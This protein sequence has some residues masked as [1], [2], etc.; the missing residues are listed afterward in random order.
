VGGLTACEE[1][2]V[3]V[4]T[5]ETRLESAPPPAPR[6]P[7]AHWERFAA[8]CDSM[9]RAQLDS[10][11]CPGAA[12]VIVQDSNIIFQQGYGLRSTSGGLPVDEHTLFRLGSISK[13]F[14]GV[15]AGIMVE[16][17]VI[18]LHERVVDILPEFVL[19]DSA[20]T[21]RIRLWHLLSHSSGLPRHTY[22]SKVEGNEDRFAILASLTTVPLAGCEGGLFAYQ[23]FAFSLIEEI[24]A[25]RTCHSYADLVEANLLA[26]AG[27]KDATIRANEWLAAE[28]KALPHSND[29]NGNFHPVPINDKYF[30][31]PSAGGIA[32]S[33]TDMGAWLK[34]L[35]GHR[36][37][38]ASVAAL[39]TA[40]FPRLE[41]HSRAF[42]DRWECALGSYYGLG[43]R[44]IDLGDHFI[45]CHGG[46]VNHYRSEIAFDRKAG[47]GVCFLYNATTSNQSSAPPDFFALYN[48][49]MDALAIE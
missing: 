27:M 20:Q 31:A 35:L 11:H 10:S 4:A 48:A 42:D 26:A 8:A 45:I 16:Q 15:L 37:E 5:V 3:P 1:T 47:I 9:F 28:N 40:F 32:A 41:T 19:S 34:V 13:G 2:K 25:R 6:L 17:G 12:M 39:D 21:Q 30:C 18:K 7:K 23:N 44:V 43:W 14:A 49:Y 36:P 22:T 29:R 33:I 38:V 46:T 24:I